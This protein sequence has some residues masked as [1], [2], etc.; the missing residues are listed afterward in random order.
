MKTLVH[1]E[2]TIYLILVFLTF[3]LSS[4][5][6]FNSPFNAFD[7]QVQAG[8]AATLTKEAF[9]RSVDSARQTEAVKNLPTETT[10]P[11]PSPSLTITPRLTPTPEP[12]HVMLPGSPIYIH[13]FVKDLV[14]V[15]LA[16]DKT[17]L[18]DNYAWSRFERP[19]TARK[20]EYRDYLDIYR[21]NLRVTDPWVYFTFILIGNLPEEGDIRYS[22][23]LDLDHEGSGEFLV[24]VK[25]PPDTQW[26]TDGVWVLEDEDDDIGGLFPLYLETPGEKQNGY[27]REIFANGLG[28]DRDLAWVRRDPNNRSQIQIA[29]KDSLIGTQGFLW[30]AWADEGLRDPSL[31]DINDHFTFEEAGSPNKDNYRYPVKAVALIDST[32]RSWY[33]YIPSGTEPG[34]CFAEELLRPSSPGYGWCKASATS[35]G[36]DGNACLAYCPSGKFCV[37][38]KLP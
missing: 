22:I 9:V 20:M 4:C 33:G 15:D 16:K 6:G 13:T 24:M 35:S 2:R 29:I 18:D 38:C 21:V 8:V 37:P 26:T 17:A 10:E 1:H 23:E 28:E 19:Y 14:T 36:C 34:L 12:V 31:F 27:E 5:L 32:C 30:S 7:N 25:I 3:S 11:T